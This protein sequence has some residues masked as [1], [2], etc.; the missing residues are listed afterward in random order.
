MA[1]S[2]KSGVISH[3]V[4]MFK[5]KVVFI[6]DKNRSSRSQYMKLKKF[7][8]SLGSIP[9]DIES[10]KHDLLMSQTSHIAHLMSYIFH[11]VIASINN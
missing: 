6:I 3:R 7:W 4:N 8:E 2:E 1:G 10:K 5:N 9:Y 11:G